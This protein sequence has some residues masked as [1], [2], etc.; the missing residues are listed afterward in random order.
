MGEVSLNE[1]FDDLSAMDLGQRAGHID[2]PFDSWFSVSIA[3]KND[4]Y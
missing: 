1:C 3:A 4:D 2:S